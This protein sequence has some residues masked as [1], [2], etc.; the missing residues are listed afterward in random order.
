MPAVLASGLVQ[1]ALG[2]GEEVRGGHARVCIQRASFSELLTTARMSPSR[3]SWAPSFTARKVSAEALLSWLRRGRT[4]PARSLSS[5]RA[6]AARDLVPVMP[7][8]SVFDL[9]V[10]L[11]PADAAAPDRFHAGGFEGFAAEAGD[12]SPGDLWRE[13]VGVGEGH[14]V[15]DVAGDGV[16]RAAGLDDGAFPAG[17]FDDGGGDV[18][19]ADGFREAVVVGEDDDLAVLARGLEDFGEAVHS[20]GVHGLDGVVDDDEA[21]GAFLEGGSRDEEAEGE[22]VELAL[23]HD[24]EGGAFL[25]VDGDFELDFA[26]LAGAAEVDVVEGDVALE[27]ELVPDAAGLVGDGGEALVADVVGRVL[28]PLLRLLEEGEGFGGLAGL[29][30]LRE[31]LGQG[32]G[33]GAPGVFAGL[34]GLNGGLTQLVK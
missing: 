15:F 13:V 3:P 4:S 5:K 34:E 22:G 6:R 19:A 1:E 8:S 27:A 32:E 20:G 31:P 26:G 29:D 11:S 2:G 7:A 25:A 24:A 10:G 14:R 33:V 18:E 12:D 28:H 16:F 17:D 21:E 23:A 9:G 30:G